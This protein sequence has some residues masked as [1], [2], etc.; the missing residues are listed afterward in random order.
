MTSREELLLVRLNEAANHQGYPEA[1]GGSWTKLAADA[2]REIERLRA[3]QR[4][5]LEEVD[6]R[7]AGVAQ[8]PAGWKLVPIEPTDEMVE[9]G[10]DNNSTQWNE[11]TDNGFAADVANDVYVSMVRAAPSP[12]TSSLRACT[13][14]PGE[15]IVPCQQKYAASEC[16][17]AWLLSLS[18]KQG[19]TP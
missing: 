5:R 12:V 14:H 4:A 1:F 3:W 11:G 15:R 8:C 19:N 18:S 17:S 13:C 7:R 6:A 16:H 2:A 9:V 10:C